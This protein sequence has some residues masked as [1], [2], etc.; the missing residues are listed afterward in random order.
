MGRRRP[1]VRPVEQTPPPPA[2]PQLSA[3]EMVKLLH[4]HVE[5]CRSAFF[6][7][8]TARA[9]DMVLYQRKTW[10]DGAHYINSE[11]QG[12]DQQLANATPMPQGQA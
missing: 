9:A 3:E 12:L 7:L 1:A 4:G 8:A 11:M 10:D 5:I 6:K 2:A